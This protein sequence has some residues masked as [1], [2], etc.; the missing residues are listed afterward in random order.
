M[1]QNSGNGP[2]TDPAPTKKKAA[3]LSQNTIY[4][5]PVGPEFIQAGIKGVIFGGNGA[6]QNSPG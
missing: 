4:S 2:G 5:Q 6:V 3:Q 1:N